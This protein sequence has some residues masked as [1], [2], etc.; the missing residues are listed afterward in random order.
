M[1]Q[2][3]IRKSIILSSLAVAIY[4]VPVAVKSLFVLKY[5]LSVTFHNGMLTTL[6][7]LKQSVAYQ[8][9]LVQ[10]SKSKKINMSSKRIQHMKAA[11][12]ASDSS[13][14]G[15]AL[16]CHIAMTHAKEHWNVHYVSSNVFFLIH[17]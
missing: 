17:Y 1:F 5:M 10:T 12:Q 6:F 4:P 9:H 13:N 2:Y 3:N 8:P 11:K 7:L 14:I 15:W 16:E